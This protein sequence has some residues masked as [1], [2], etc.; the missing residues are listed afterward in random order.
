[1]KRWREKLRS[2]RGAKDAR[3]KSA[4]TLEPPAARSIASAARLREVRQASIAIPHSPQAFR[5]R[6]NIPQEPL[7]ALLAQKYLAVDRKARYAS[8]RTRHRVLAS[9]TSNRDLGFCR[10]QQPEL[11][12]AHS[13]PSHFASSCPSEQLFL[14]AQPMMQDIV[15]ITANMQYISYTMNGISANYL[16]TRIYRRRTGD[17]PEESPD[18]GGT[19]RCRTFAG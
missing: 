10:L 6:R 7:P 3:A 9:T 14:K 1:M 15:D 17:A 8:A 4:A 5:R 12:L 11:L 16:T 13:R 18:E 2:G 19:S